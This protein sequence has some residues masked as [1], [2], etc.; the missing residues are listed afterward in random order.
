VS[1]ICL[2]QSDPTE[3]ID[4]LITTYRRLAAMDPPAMRSL[5]G[6][7]ERMSDE[8]F[9]SV[10]QQSSP[11]AQ[12]KARRVAHRAAAARAALAWVETEA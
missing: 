8:S 2:D 12:A 4:G 3:D 6:E 9:A 10:G 1:G 7:L 5:I 11:A